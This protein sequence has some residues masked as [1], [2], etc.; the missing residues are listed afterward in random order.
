MMA[1]SVIVMCSGHTFVQHLVMLQYPIPYSAF[2]SGMRSAVSSGFISTDAAYTRKRGPMDS[3]GLGW[4]LRAWDTSGQRKHSMHLRNS[5]TRSM[6]SCCIRQVPSAASGGRGL[7]CLIFFLTSKFH[8][9][10]VTRSRIDGNA[11]IGSMVIG[12]SVGS[13]F[14]RVMHM[15]LAMP[16]I[17]AEHEPHLPALQFQ[18]TAR[19]LAWSAWIW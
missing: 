6:S 4:A 9:T 1:L 8:D 19:S 11:W 3:A 17:S 12:L 2:S 16:L 15:S 7:N 10:S 14:M 13:V 18:R 5:C